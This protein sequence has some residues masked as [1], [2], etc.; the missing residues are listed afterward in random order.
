M[1]INETIKRELLRLIESGYITVKE[2]PLQWGEIS[3]SFKVQ[4]G[5]IMMFNESVQRTTK[6][7]V[8][9]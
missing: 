3:L 5:K 1:P 9:S 2:S 8:V 7:E 6:I 4:A